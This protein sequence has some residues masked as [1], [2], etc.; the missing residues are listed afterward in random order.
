[1]TV[2]VVEF[3]DPWCSWAWGTEPTLRKLRWSFED[4]LSWRR[5]MGGLVPNRLEREPDFDAVS[6][7]PNT[8]SYWA[9]VTVETGMPWP[10]HLQRTP[11]SS[12]EACIAVKAAERQDEL[13]A[14]RFLRRLRESCFV[15]CTPADTPERIAEVAAQVDGL[16][17]AAVT[18]GLTDNDVLSAYQAD[19]EETRNPN[20]YVRNLKE[21][22]P[23]AG[24]AKQQRGR[25]RYVFPTLLF[26][27]PGGEHTVPGW[28]PY[29]AYVAAMEAASP[30]STADPRPDPTPDD[31]MARWG[32]LTEQ[33]LTVLCGPDAKPPSGAVVHDWGEGR[34][35]LPPG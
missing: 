30:G 3:T 20:E 34:V 31:A 18:T 33:E 1:M 2:D 6:I 8:A 29:G 23:G 22:T 14:Q 9:K 12:I 16:D 5:V 11:V 21:E 19:W 13:L 4:R 26:R 15:W 7:A 32:L 28:K 24:N 10:V 35:F 27:G 25:W 17:A